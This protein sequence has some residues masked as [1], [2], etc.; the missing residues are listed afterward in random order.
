MPPR[1]WVAE[2]DLSTPIE[3][4]D[5]SGAKLATVEILLPDCVCVQKVK[6]YF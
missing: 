4:I 5:D 1:Q 3:I 6:R 2:T